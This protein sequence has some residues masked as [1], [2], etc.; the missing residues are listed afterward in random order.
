MVERIIQL[1]EQGSLI[2]VMEEPQVQRFYRYELGGAFIVD[3]NWIVYYPVFP[4]GPQDF[5]DS[6]VENLVM[7]S[8][9]CEYVDQI[10]R[11]IM[12]G[13]FEEIDREAISVFKRWEK[14]K[15]LF[16]MRDGRR[17]CG[18]KDSIHQC[19]I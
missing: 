1:A 3:K 13:R 8:T 6:V 2:Y 7:N 18:G 17:R 16:S 14:E 11:L 4:D 9:G 15:N 19:L 12:I 10:G 5:H